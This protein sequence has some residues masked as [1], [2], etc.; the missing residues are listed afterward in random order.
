MKFSFWREEIVILA[1]CTKRRG[2]RAYLSR[3]FRHFITISDL[4][5]S[6]KDVV[7]NEDKAPPCETP[8]LSG[9]LR[10]ARLCF[11]S[12]CALLR[13]TTWELRRPACPFSGMITSFGAHGDNELAVFLFPELPAPA[14]IRH[15]SK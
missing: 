4:T 3:Y 15:F 6:L 5:K 10:Y 2:K 12:E 11:C 9:K 1:D 14:I 7:T 13:Q 8:L